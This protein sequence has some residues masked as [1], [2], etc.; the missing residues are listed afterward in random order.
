MSTRRAFLTTLAAGVLAKP[1]D[2]RAQ[3]TSKVPHIGWLG[4]PSRES[5][6]PFVQP[7]LQGLREL[8]W[9]EGDNLVIEW[10]FGDGQ[11]ERLPTLAAELVRLN[12]NLIVVPSTPTAVAAR[13]A[14]RSIPLVSV[15]GNDPV[16]LGFAASLARPGGNFTGLTVSLG[17]EIAGKQVE[18]LKAAVPTISRM[19]ALWN[20]VTPGNALALKEAAAAARGLKVEFYPR[21]ARGVGDF[22][23]A[24]TAMKTKRAGALLVL[25]DVMFVTHRL[26]L[27]RLAATHRLPA[28]YS[29][30]E[31]VDDGGLMSYNADVSE[32][33]RRA[34][35]YVDKI[36]KGATPGDLPIERP[37]KFVLAINLKA[38]K[39]LGLTIPEAL[40]Q[41]ADEV[42]R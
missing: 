36:L 18:L 7:F 20:P 1:S 27:A 12:V 23:G 34:A 14:T 11:A 8:G 42:I 30:R 4:G 10:R 13:N 17:P 22:D 41:R 38:A 19:A 5:A 3:Q 39:A 9:F 35:T 28:M 2:T 6:Q 33:F 15:G 31:F 26:R 24:F 25:A 32:N 21:E 37:T 40:V 16:A 29:Q